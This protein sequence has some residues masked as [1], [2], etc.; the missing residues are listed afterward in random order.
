[1]KTK[2]LTF[3][4]A[5]TFL[6][7]FSGSVFGD[8][9]Q[10]GVDAYQKQDY[11]TAYKFWLPLAEQGNA[12]AQN[13]LGWMYSHGQGVPQDYKEAVKWYR[14]SADQGY[15]EAQYNL[16]WMYSKGRGVPQD[17]VSAHMWWNLSGSNGYEDAVENRNMVE[18]EMS[19]TQIEKA[20]EM[21]RNWKPKQEPKGLE[22]SKGLFEQFK[23]KFGIK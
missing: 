3:L 14:L 22:E 15:A 16:G 21:A 1:M 9:F 20:Q 2:P 8:D 4:L 6:F 12:T 13:N 5:L 23:E 17:Y 7:L 11:K 18:K 10:D 19:T